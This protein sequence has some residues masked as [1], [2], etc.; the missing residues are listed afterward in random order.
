MG[1]QAI[2]LTRY[3]PFSCVKAHRRENGRHEKVHE[4]HEDRRHEEGHEEVDEEG[5][6]EGHEEEVDEEVETSEQ[7]REGKRARSLVFSGKKEKTA[8]G[9]KASELV[10]NKSG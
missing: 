8:S 1:A 3:R 9:L 4:G 6:E 5:H 7:D 10:K 2:L